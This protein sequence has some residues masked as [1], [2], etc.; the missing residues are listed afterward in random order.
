MASRFSPGIAD[1]PTGTDG[2]VFR[3]GVGWSGLDVAAAGSFKP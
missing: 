2:S 1:V 3:P